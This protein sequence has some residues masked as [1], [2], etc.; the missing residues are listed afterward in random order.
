MLSRLGHLSFL[1]VLAAA[2]LL[3]SA[4]LVIAGASSQG[5]D[6]RLVSTVWPPFTSPDRQQRF[7]LDLVEAGLDRSGVPSAT[8][9]V[10]NAQYTA[11]VTS[12]PF[13]G[14]GAVWHD[15]Q[16]EKALIF[17]QPYLENRLI[18]IAR[19]GGDVSAAAPAALKGRRL[20][21]VEGYAYGE[22]L[23]QSG[24]SLVRAKSQEDSLRLLLDSKV[25]YALMDALV[26]QYILE[27]YPEE[28]RTRLQIGT[29]SLVTRPLHL[30]VRRSRPDAE[31]II[32]RFNA[33]LRAMVTDRTY[34]RLLHVDWIRADVDGDGVLENVAS[35]DQPGKQPP[36]YAYPL[37]SSAAIEQ[38]VLKDQERYFFGGA[39]YNGWSSVPD[40]Y[41]VDDLGRTD[42]QHPT[43]RIF[44]FSWK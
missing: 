29:V 22:Q 28:A 17:S 7:A 20:A 9:F 27:N 43:A 4:T 36:Q 18:L 12:G 21:V 34:H 1:R 39:V 16:R 11:A 30:A 41:K 38:Q 35:S 5:K 33:Q 25:D 31:S 23:E 19:R 42:A 10:D 8:T 44:T 2:G 37:F 3:F 13:D 24:A 15:A 26:V 32:Q 14:S 40:R 6:L